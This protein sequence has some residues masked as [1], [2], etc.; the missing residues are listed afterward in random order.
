MKVVKKVKLS[1]ESLT[2]AIDYLKQYKQSFEQ[3][4]EKFRNRIAAEIQE[5]AQASFDISVVDDLI[6]ESSRTANVEVSLDSRKNVTFVVAEGEDV[7]W[8]EF[9]A[10]VYHNS[11]VG[12]S[13]H[14]KG[15]H[16]GFTI[17]SFGKGHGKQKAWVYVDE[18]GKH[19]THG[20]PG[21]MPLFKASMDVVEQ[22]R[23]IAREVFG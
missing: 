12:T 16:F 9:G 14:P 4:V 8:V 18:D 21:T 3:K 6:G 19:L 20:T 1:T 17:G 10:G 23:D 11:P 22:V 5:V 15:S 13:P 2:E 7:I